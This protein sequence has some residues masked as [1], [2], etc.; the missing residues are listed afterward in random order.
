MHAERLEH[1]QLAEGTVLTHLPSFTFA[2]LASLPV[3]F[4][5]VS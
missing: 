1:I 4:R 5:P 2:G 3:T